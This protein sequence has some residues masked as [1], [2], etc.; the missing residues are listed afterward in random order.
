MMN[1]DE[2][3]ARHII[4]VATLTAKLRAV[5]EKH[6]EAVKDAVLAGVEIRP[7]ARVSG[8]SH[9]TVGSLKR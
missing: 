8:L 2:R 3:D 6:R 1:R 7:L 9:V 4:K 5:T